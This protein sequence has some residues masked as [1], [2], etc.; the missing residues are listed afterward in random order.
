MRRAVAG[1][2][3]RRPD[4]AEDRR[5]AVR[6]P[7]RRAVRPRR[8]AAASPRWCRSRFAPE[9]LARYG[10]LAGVSLDAEVALRRRALSREPAL[11][12]S[13]AVGPG[14]PADLVVLAAG[15]APSRSHRPAA[16]RRR[17][18]VAR[19]SARSPARAR[20][21]CSPSGCRSASRSSG[22]TAHGVDAAAARS[23][24]D[25][26]LERRRA[27]ARTTGACS[28]RARSATTRPRSRSGGV[29][30]RAL[31]SKTMEATRRAGPVLHRRGGRRDRLA[32]R[33]Q[34]PVGVGVGRRGGRCGVSG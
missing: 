30:T 26:A 2:R 20:R 16:G 32:R 5:D 1:R 28:R 3:H 18:R 25:R 29:D 17:A 22:A 14:D 12:P 15:G 23:C 13:R 8:R 34:L 24:R 11:H 21:R 9:L 10:E 31:S 6:L 19:A 7:D 33:L 4:G 27:R